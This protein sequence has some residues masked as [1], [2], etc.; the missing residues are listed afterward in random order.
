MYQFSASVAISK[1]VLPLARMFVG[2]FTPAR[3][4]DFRCWYKAIASLLRPTFSRLSLPSALNR[5]HQTPLPCSFSQTPVAF[6]VVFRGMASSCGTISKYPHK[7]HQHSEAQ[8][9]PRNDRLWS[10]Q[11]I[12]FGMFILVPGGGVEPPRPCGRRIL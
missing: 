12:H 2:N 5:I 6:A 11:L 9:S 1:N 10:L 8:K 7:Y 3:S 4:S